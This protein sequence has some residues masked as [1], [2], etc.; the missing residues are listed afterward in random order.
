MA[1]CINLIHPPI[2]NDN[3]ARWTCSIGINSTE[4]WA[5]LAILLRQRNPDSIFKYFNSKQK[6][7]IPKDLSAAFLESRGL[8]ALTHL[9][10]KPAYCFHLTNSP[11]GIFCD[12]WNC[13][14]LFIQGLLQRINWKPCWGSQLAMSGPFIASKEGKRGNKKKQLI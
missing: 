6:N 14:S 7:S 2:L 12:M 13:I 11:C 10:C 5:R 1:V 8:C 4:D 3:T 9:K